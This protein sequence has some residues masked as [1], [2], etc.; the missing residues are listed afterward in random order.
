MIAAKRNWLRLPA[1]EPNKAMDPRELMRR[2]AGWLPW[3]PKDG[4]R[5]RQGEPGPI[6]ETMGSSF[7]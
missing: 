5:P 7:P 2:R 6:K 1:E 4:K 3:R